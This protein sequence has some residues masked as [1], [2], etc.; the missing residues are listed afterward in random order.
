M[1]GRGIVSFIPSYIAKEF[2]CFKFAIAY[3][4]KNDMIDISSLKSF[5]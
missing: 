2:C 3:L 1:E 5:M 4:R